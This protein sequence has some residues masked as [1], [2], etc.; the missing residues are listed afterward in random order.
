MG[1][2]FLLLYSPDDF[3]LDTRCWEFYL[4]N[5]GYFCTT[6]NILELCSVNILELNTVKLLKDGVTL[7][8]IVFKIQVRVELRPGFIIYH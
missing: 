4:L 1:P 2:I 3:L 8:G 7:W 6:V 5:V